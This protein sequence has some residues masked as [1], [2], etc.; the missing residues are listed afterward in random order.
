M[1]QIRSRSDNTV[2]SYKFTLNLYFS[3]LQEEKDKPLVDVTTSDFCQKEILLFMDWLRTKR[4]NEVTT[5]NQRLS[6]IGAFCSFLNKNGL[7][8]YSDMNEIADINKLPDMRKQEVPFLTVEN[9]K[10]IL[11]QPDATKKNGVRDKFILR[12]FMTVDAAIRKFLI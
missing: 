2:T 1:P 3:F 4:G 12:C 7:I 8:S 10:L 11:E 6:N 9:V 5:V